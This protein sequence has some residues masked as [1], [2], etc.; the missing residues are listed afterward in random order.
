M[1][2]YSDNWDYSLSGGAKRLGYPEWWLRQVGFLDGPPSCASTCAYAV[3][4]KEMEC[5]TQGNHCSDAAACCTKVCH[6]RTS[7]A[8]VARLEF[9]LSTST[10]FIFSFSFIK[11]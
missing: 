6:E 7:A 3:D 10:L 1:V 9:Q 8:E 2:Q 4:E 5:L 11:M